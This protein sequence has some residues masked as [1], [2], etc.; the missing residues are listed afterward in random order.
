VG[1]DRTIDSSTGSAST[2]TA[3]TSAGAADTSLDFG[4]VKI[5]SV[6]VGNYVWMDVDKDG[7][8]DAGESG[9]SG[10]VLNITGPGGSAVTD[11]YGNT[12]GSTTTNASGAYL[13]SNLP[14]LT[15]G[16]SYTVTIDA[17]ASAAALAGLTATTAGAGADR[18][19]DSST[20][21]A[22]SATTLTTDGASD[23]TLDFGYFRSAVSVGNFVWLDTDKDGI[24][25]A[26]ESGIPGVV[27]KIT[28]PGGSAVT[29]INGSA[30]GPATTNAS[31]A[32][33]SLISLFLRP[34]RA[35]QSQSMRRLPHWHL[36]D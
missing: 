5:P 13:F 7:I 9:I 28:G 16:Q 33:L 21:S 10:V 14:A 36:P 8:Q 20:G 29:D 6:S 12:V 27:L 18:T 1:G 22:I 15:A 26:G 19:V 30:V 25:D 23:L 24:Q 35:I 3:L 11:I 34:G 2:I 31:G 32:Y 4:Y 17:T